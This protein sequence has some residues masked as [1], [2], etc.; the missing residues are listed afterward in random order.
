V[1]SL[2]I[3]ENLANPKKLNHLG[4]NAI[5]INDPLK[6]KDVLTSNG[7][8]YPYPETDNVHFEYAQQ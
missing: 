3:P 7:W 4:G 1:D 6:W 5:D 2:K 8:K